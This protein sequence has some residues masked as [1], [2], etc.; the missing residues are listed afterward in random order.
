M[1]ERAGA[2][3]I[4]KKVSLTFSVA[5]VLLFKVSFPALELGIPFFRLGCDPSDPPPPP[6]AWAAG[7]QAVRIKTHPVA[8]KLRRISFVSGT[9]RYIPARYKRYY[10]SLEGGFAEYLASL[11]AD[12]RARFRKLLRKMSASTGGGV[13]CRVYR[14]PEEATEFQS[15]A[16]GISKKSWQGR[17][18]KGGVRDD[19]DSAARLR[20]LAARDA[21]RGYV[22][23]V[24]DVAVAYAYCEAENGAL[25][26][27]KTGYDPA[28]GQLSPGIV[29][30]WLL[31]ERLFAE[32]RFH[33]LDFGEGGLPHKAAFA[34]GSTEC[35]EICYFRR[36]ARNLALVL[37]HAGIN[38]VTGWVARLLEK[39]GLKD[40]IRTGIHRRLGA[41]RP[42][43]KVPSNSHK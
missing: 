37:A 15:L 29:L 5:G 32:N 27:Q 11:S 26:L 25:T 31:L 39:V 3:W 35:A 12:R 33:L 1:E 4:E 9:I 17:L 38:T 7:R 22:L 42:E 28:F 6:D 2:P 21:I 43:R 13:D 20:D 10:V 23:L 40:R 41:S 19:V 36:T 30:R 14:R 34:T 8:G 18:L 24:G 16:H